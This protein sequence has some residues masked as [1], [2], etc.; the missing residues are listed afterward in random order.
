MTRPWDPQ[1]ERPAAL[2][3]A[4]QSSEQFILTTLAAQIYAVFLPRP[5]QLVERLPRN[6]IGKLSLA[7]LLELAVR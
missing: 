5:L 2:V 7:Q 1:G 6:H 3:V 4:P